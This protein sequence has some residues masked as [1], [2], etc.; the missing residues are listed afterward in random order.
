MGRVIELGAGN[1]IQ[2]GAA[3]KLEQPIVQVNL[4]NDWTVQ[5]FKDYIQILRFGQFYY[6]YKLTEDR[7]GFCVN[8]TNAF[9]ISVAD[10]YRSLGFERY[11][12]KQE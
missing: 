9:E 1:Q 11:T 3:P 7:M 8:K 12:P 4:E 5:V 6:K 2:L 10:I